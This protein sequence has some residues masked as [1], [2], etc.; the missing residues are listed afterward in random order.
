M[1]IKFPRWLRPWMRFGVP[2]LVVI[3]LI[4]DKLLKAWLLHTNDSFA[5]YLETVTK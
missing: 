2:V 5:H 1:G 4:M 3:I